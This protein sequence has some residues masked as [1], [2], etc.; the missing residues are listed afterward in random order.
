MFNCTSSYGYYVTLMIC[1]FLVAID[2]SYT[3]N[4]S[5]VMPT[6]RQPS[7]VPDDDVT[8]IPAEKFESC[9]NELRKHEH[10]LKDRFH[11]CRLI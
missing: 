2:Q 5:A 7:W 3:S 10:I 1:P 6:P 11:V 4:G 8:L 9:F